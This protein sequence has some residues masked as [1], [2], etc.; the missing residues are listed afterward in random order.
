MDSIFD[1]KAALKSPLWTKSPAPNDMMFLSSASCSGVL[2]K[3]GKSGVKKSRYCIIKDFSFLYYHSKT[4]REPKNILELNY[5]RFEDLSEEKA[6]PGA[7]QY[8]F[9]LINA[10]RCYEYLTTSFE[11]YKR[12]TEELKQ[13]CVRM[14]FNQ[15]YERLAVIGSGSF[16]KVHKAK[17]TGSTT[18]FAIKSISKT[19]IEESERTK[20]NIITEINIMKILDHP[21][22]I[23]MYEVYESENHI[24]MVLEYLEG[25][26]LFE[27]VKKNGQYSE[28]KA[29]RIMKQF[30]KALQYLH[31]K[32][33]VHCDLKPENVLLGARDTDVK[34]ADFGLASKIEGNEPLKLRCGSP[35]YIAPEVLENIG[36]GCIADIF[37]AGVILYIMLCGFPP[38]GGDNLRELIRCNKKCRW[39]FISPYWDPVSP[40]AKDIVSKMMEKDPKKRLT[41][42]QALKHH[43]ITGGEPVTH[44]S[45]RARKKSSS[46]GMDDH[47]PGIQDHISPMGSPE[48]DNINIITSTPLF[49]GR[50]KSPGE[51]GADIFASPI[52][53]Y[54]KVKNDPN[55]I[56]SASKRNS[57]S[58]AMGIIG[59]VSF[60]NS[61][62]RKMNAGGHKIPI[63]DPATG[64]KYINREKMSPR[65]RIGESDIPSEGNKASSH[66][67]DTLNIK[68][69]FDGNEERK[70]G[71]T[72]S[73]H[74]AKA[75]K[76]VLRQFV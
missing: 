10:G 54:S 27:K 38:F 75:I 22:I 39:E 35:G 36:Y 59:G 40:A 21:Y 48:S 18:T 58:K 37:S 3:N 65:H 50:V 72:T 30:L 63:I 56:L 6:L 64:V 24:H 19:K 49:S 60:N 2:F 70:E 43:F 11:D 31:A 29:A 4:D 20:E 51:K 5:T 45:P 26:E 68:Q 69:K 14:H 23:K 33:I 41:A 55:A 42:E 57:T 25:G 61:L 16:A 17:K 15:Q 76:N 7:K 44:L 66:L 74:R 47:L 34:L 13:K 71:T 67:T 52:K 73:N 53:K 46:A 1:D 12:W 32:N 28:E 62:H 9:R 8:G